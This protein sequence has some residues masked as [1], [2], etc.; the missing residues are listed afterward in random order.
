LS[1]KGV[2]TSVYRTTF[3]ISYLAFVDD[4]L[5]VDGRIGI[6]AVS[7]RAVMKICVYGAGPHGR[8]TWSALGQK[9]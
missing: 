1:A 5:T 2:G 6:Y 8:A 3:E 4:A 9:R 7:G